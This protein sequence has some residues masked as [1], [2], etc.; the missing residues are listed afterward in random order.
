MEF[1]EFSLILLNS[2]ILISKGGTMKKTARFI[3]FLG[4]L[5]VIFFATYQ[6]LSWKDTNG[7]YE[8]SVTRLYETKENTIDV[9]FYGSSHCFCAILPYVLW[10]EYGMSAFNM[11]TSGQDREATYYYIKEL[12]KTQEPKVI[13]VDLFALTYDGYGV[14]GNEYRNMLSMDLSKNN[15]EMIQ[16]VVDEE[17][18]MDYILKW[19]IIHT[20][21]AELEKY[22]FEL[23]DFSVFGRGEVIELKRAAINMDPSV[24]SYEGIGEVPEH[25]LE[26]VDRLIALSEEEGFELVFYTAPFEL[27]ADT[28][29]IYNAASAYFE[30]RGIMYLDFNDY[31][32]SIDS[33]IDYNA[34]FID[35]GHVNIYGGQKITEYIGKKLTEK[36]MFENHRGDEEYVFWEQDLEYC[37]HALQEPI[38]KNTYDWNAYKDFILN[39]E[40]LAVVI[41]LD[42]K[43]DESTLN[44]FGMLVP[45]ELESGYSEGGK[46][47]IENGEITT[48][49][50]EENQEIVFLDL[51]EDTLRVKNGPS[52][53]SG[54]DIVLSGVPQ[55]CIDNG[56]TVLIYD[57]VLHRV[58]D[59]KSWF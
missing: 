26:W 18:Q 43:Y 24:L 27:N 11:G 40:D 13:C 51:G 45:L 37:Q 1:T 52:D 15:V 3:I 7:E 33:G 12:L 48:R 29:A 32:V 28:K 49:L 2:Y 19:P 54:E 42:G 30:E 25:R 5:V 41:S 56:L 8:D 31:E 53:D 34:D 16:S 46:W 50:V 20:R 4:I 21:Y 22:D 44:L 35:G 38:I 36:Y 10:E 14:K 23:N 39:S 59:R 57:K 9:A 47:V 58:V 17:D 55:T 6:V